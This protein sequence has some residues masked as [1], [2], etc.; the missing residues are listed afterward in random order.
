MDDYITIDQ[1]AE[2]LSLSRRQI[3][4][5]RSQGHLPEPDLRIGRGL[6]WSS[7]RIALWARENYAVVAKKEAN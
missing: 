4:R 7:S 2:K 5:L 3:A 6:R 1:I